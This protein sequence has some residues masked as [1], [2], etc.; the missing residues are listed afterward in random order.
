MTGNTVGGWRHA[1]FAEGAGVSAR[2]NSVKDAV[3]AAFRI[4]GNPAKILVTGNQVAGAGVQE[5]LLEPEAK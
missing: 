5:L 2:Q 3:T 4:R 1:L